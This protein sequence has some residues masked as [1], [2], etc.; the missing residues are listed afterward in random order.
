MNGF[1]IDARIAP[2]R[3]NVGDGN[4]HDLW[5]GIGHIVIVV[6]GWF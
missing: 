1:V 4:H 3:A 6:G 5:G 2:V